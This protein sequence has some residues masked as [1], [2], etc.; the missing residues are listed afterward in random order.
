[1]SGQTRVGI[2]P[3]VIHRNKEVFSDDAD[4]FR[5]E[6]WMERD[7]KYMS[8]YM[9]QVGWPTFLPRDEASWGRVLTQAHHSL[10]KV[11]GFVLAGI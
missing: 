8:R 2:N 11:R 10:V 3:Y 9:L 5:P 6:R 1:M 4:I 7:E